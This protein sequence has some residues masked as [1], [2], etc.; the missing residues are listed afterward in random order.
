MHHNPRRSRQWFLGTGDLAG[1]W[2]GTGAG[3]ASRFQQ[4]QMGWRTP[5]VS[6]LSLGCCVCFHILTHMMVAR[7][8][9]LSFH[10]EE[11]KFSCCWTTSFPDH[12]ACKALPW[13]RMGSQLHCQPWR[14][15]TWWP[16]GNC[17]RVL[18]SSLDFSNVTNKQTY[19]LSKAEQGECDWRIIF[20]FT[21]F[22]K[23]YVDA[24]SVK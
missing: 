5:V 21:L 10:M 17:Q 18:T 16:K 13:E 12:R 3:S 15:I 6:W 2:S 8:I 22:L 14:R 1:F 11:G 19:Q 20:T 23:A 4:W 24:W 7:L 9:I